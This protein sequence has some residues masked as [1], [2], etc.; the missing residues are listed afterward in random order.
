MYL[1]SYSL[2]KAATQCVLGCDGLVMRKLVAMWVG[3]H[4]II[5]MVLNLLAAFGVV[6]TVAGGGRG[7]CLG[8]F[9]LVPIVV[10]II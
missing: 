5:A 9:L 10:M 6:V 8:A 2:L 7:T 1:T 4:H 3:I